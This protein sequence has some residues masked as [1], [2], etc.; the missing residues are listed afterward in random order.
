MKN[1]NARRVVVVTGASAGLGRAIAR[2]FAR[3]ERARIGL[4][5]RGKVGLEAAKSDTEISGGEALI[6]SA[7]VADAPSVEAAAETSA[8]LVGGFEC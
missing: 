4:I 6:L 8:V 5:A 3:G 2:A 1:G 7:D